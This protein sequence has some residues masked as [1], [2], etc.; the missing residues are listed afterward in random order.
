VLLG[1]RA[2]DRDRS[3]LLQ[4]FDEATSDFAREWIET[5]RLG[6]LPPNECRLL[7]SA[8][9]GAAQARLEV[10]VDTMVEESGGSPF[11][12]GEMARHI[13]A[14]AA[15][16]GA[17][18]V[19]AGVQ[20]ADATWDRVRTLP[21]SARR[22]LEL[23]SV[24]PGPIDRSTVLVAAGIGESGRPLISTLARQSLVRTT[25]IVDRVAI[26]PYHE[27]IRES[28]VAQLPAAAVAAHHRALALALEA[29]GDA[30]ADALAR[31]FHGAGDLEK[32][33]RYAVEGAQRAASALAFLRAA[34]L[35]RLALEWRPGTEESTRRLQVARG[36][37]LV[38]AGRSAEAARLFAT[39]GA[40]APRRDA[41]E[42]RGRAVEQFLAAGLID[43]GV[44]VL[45]ELARDLGLRYP[46]TATA[47]LR[48]IALRLAQLRLRGIAFRVRPAGEIPAEDLTRIDLCYSVGKGL[49]M[50][51][52]IRGI[53]FDG[54]A[55]FLALRAGD[56]VRIGRTLVPVATAL[57]C[58][59][60]RAAIRWGDAL[61]DTAQ[62][63]ATDTGD[64]YGLGM[65]ALARSQAS[66]YMGGWR[67]AA[68]DA[69]EGV[70]I[71]TNGCR[72]ATLES[73]I[74]RM[75]A[76]R[77]LEE[78]GRL[79]EVAARAEELLVTAEAVGDRYA[80][81][82]ALLNLAFSAIA[83]DDLRGARSRA[84]RAVERWT[85]QGFNLQHLYAMR[86]EAYADL[87]EGHAER[88]WRRVQDTWPALK[89]SY[90]ARLPMIRMDAHILR[91]RVALALG[92]E[93]RETRTGLLRRCERDV[94]V[95]ERE[96]RRDGTAHALLLRAGISAR[97]GDQARSLELVERAALAYEQAD[98]AV[99]AACAL[100]RR[101]DLVGGEKGSEQVA[102]ADRVLHGAGIRNAARWVTIHAPGFGA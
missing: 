53:Y 5:I 87:Y 76:M 50:V 95:V 98:M 70:R 67:N 101:G 6:P 11:F 38:N 23:V 55:L 63:I 65:A 94:R 51:D 47:A 42:L 22:V 25:T 57:R 75:S 66:L 49:A 99:D 31:H 52:S 19:P 15:R 21:R 83:D 59:R 85:Q 27:R 79:Q 78:L 45:R 2:E 93:R 8:L 80:E 69:D 82:T 28:V 73:N 13:L 60:N 34:E 72:G 81:V 33:T 91:A 58:L 62:R 18:V 10:D 71:L 24:A 1:Y 17:L 44:G 97:L 102:A 40:A 7:A 29:S 64:V 4:A 37:A 3:P 84:H 48:A 12:V 26:G 14:E 46:A 54:E 90:L 100:R 86:V 89:S 36:D 74:A 88:A 9:L 43:E 20:L 96:G 16:H 61:L 41:L 68:A 77:A 92:T 35:Y 56:P 32:A 39:A 30:D